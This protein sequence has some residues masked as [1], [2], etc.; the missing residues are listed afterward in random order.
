[1]SVKRLDKHI[2]FGYS[3]RD[4]MNLNRLGERSSIGWS[5]IVWMCVIWLKESELNE[6]A[7]IDF[8]VKIW[9]TWS[10]MSG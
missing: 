5:R 2:T 3:W 9:L 1:M 4:C 8:K 6:K 10:E 7:G